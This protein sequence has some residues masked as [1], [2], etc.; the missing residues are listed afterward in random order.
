M[1]RVFL[2]ALLLFACSTSLSLGQKTRFG[3]KVEPPNPADFTLKVHISASHIRQRCSG[4]GNQV[5]CGDRLDADAMLNGKKL[6]LSGTPISIQKHG[7]VII[8]GD[9]SAHLTQ[10]IHNA[11][12]SAIYREYDLL[13]PDNTVWH[14]SITGISE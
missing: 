12:S 3:Q 11:D 6:E 9:Y 1:M 5:Y 13:L 2:A 8:P 7:A 4:G 14:C 10:D